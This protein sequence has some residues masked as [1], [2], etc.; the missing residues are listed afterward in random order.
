[1]C[2]VSVRSV[3]DMECVKRI[4]KYL[5]GKRR[6][7]CLFLWQQRGDLETYSDAD[8]GRSQLVSS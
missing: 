3:R 8:W 2:G 5:V 7:K 1:M 4:G 6:A